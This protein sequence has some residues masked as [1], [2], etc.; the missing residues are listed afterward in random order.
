MNKYRY[1][2]NLILVS[3]LIVTYSCNEAFLEVVPTTQ[4]SAETVFADK[5]GADLFLYDV[6]NGLPDAEAM[7]GYN[8]DS[9][10]SWGDN[11]V[12]KFNWSISTQKG[13]ARDYGANNYNPGLYNHDY[14]ALPFI[15]DKMFVRIRKC[16]VFI[17][18]V[19]ENTANFPAEW[20]KPRLAEARFLRAYYYHQAW[21]AYG[22]LPIITEPLDRIAQGD[23][24][25][26]PRA[27]F[28]ETFKF[29]TNEL[30][31]C[32]NELPNEVGTGR[33][34]KGA[35]LTLKGWCELFAKRY[36]LAAATNKQVMDLGVYDLFP[37]YNKQFFAENNNNTES[38]F[39]YQHI[40]GTKPS[41]R[42]MLFGPSGAYNAW[43][44]MQATQNL[45]DDYQMSNGLP[46]S[47]PN[48]GFDPNQPY[49]NRESRFYQSIIYDKAVFAGKTYSISELYDPAR[50]NQTGYFRRKGIS[51]AILLNS[52]EGSN[53]VY[54]RY[55]EVLLN[56]AEAKIEL[57]QIDATVVG[58][59]NKVR[60][61]AG[62]PSLEDTYKKSSF[63]QSELRTIAR[64]ERRIEL[65]FE[66]KRYWDLI[67]WKTAEVV[68]NQPVYGINFVGGK[69]VKVIAHSMQFNA[70]KNYLFPIYQPW[71]DSNPI[72]K[73]QTN[74]EMTNGQ[75]P[76]Y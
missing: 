5:S 24:I 66:V 37:D 69:Y 55:A 72:W 61:R 48:S 7:P 51:E 2:K 26:Y 43:G 23:E 50:E 49:L 59:I 36:D 45:V 18:N 35:A 64:T 44:A 9:F 17:K 25:Y 8:Y 32:A 16:N 4:L 63:T 13:I 1:L 3:F 39:A 21:M 73:T 75:N 54:F 14:P 41:G 31:A 28:E 11:A 15:Y 57:N 56:Y 65:A 74:A 52:Q 27:T 33:A 30:G 22:G 38:I 29:I 60:N 19:T 40:T 68:L 42:S 12:C 71:I 58:A 34:T 20:S 47:D 46:I 62:L 70:S 53:F 6:Y 76:G 10:E 67:R